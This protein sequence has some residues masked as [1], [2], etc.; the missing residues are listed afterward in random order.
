MAFSNITFSVR[1]PALCKSQKILITVKKTF[2]FLGFGKSN[3]KSFWIFY[4]F[5]FAINLKSEEYDLYRGATT[6][7][8]L[9]KY[10][11]QKSS[12][13]SP[14]FVWRSDIIQM[15]PFNHSCVGID[16]KQD[17]RVVLNILSKYS[18]SIIF[19]LNQILFVILM[20]SCRDWFME[21]LHSCFCC[22]FVSHGSSTKFKPTVLL[23]MWGHFGHHYVF[24]H[25]SLLD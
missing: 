16:T 23:H 9:S 1:Q 10:E 19:W 13:T 11:N 2:Y 7:E 12:W 3:C 6:E 18:M 8:V 25:S 4:F 24:P 21:G 17:H 20:H 22:C 15:D 5:Q 14:F